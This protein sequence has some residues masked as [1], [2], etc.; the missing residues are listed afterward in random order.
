MSSVSCTP[1]FPEDAGAPAAFYSPAMDCGNILF[2]S[3][4]VAL[5]PDGSFI[6]D[7]LQNEVKQIF[8]NIDALLK[9]SKTEKTHIAK[10][11]V[12]LTDLKDY[13]EFNQLYKEYLEGH[14]PA[15][16]CIQVAQLPLGARVEVEAIVHR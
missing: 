6:N 5:T 15:R 10:I 2:F 8:T 14:A 11:T 4:Q 16:T 12:F 9:A 1:V 3:G 13:E 7:S